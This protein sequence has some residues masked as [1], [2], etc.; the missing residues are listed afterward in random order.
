MEN[1]LY[2]NEIINYM[3]RYYDVTSEELIEVLNTKEN[4]YILLLLL[5][6]HNCLNIKKLKDKYKFEEKIRIKNRLKKA[7]EM[8]L[9]NTFFR[10]KYFM[11][12]NYIEK[13]NAN[14]KK[15]L[16]INNNM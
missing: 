15:T 7:E 1:K 3:C 16:D 14:T 2:Y 5:K 4:I 9:I 12:E 10:E 8:L 11:I 13:N 6:K